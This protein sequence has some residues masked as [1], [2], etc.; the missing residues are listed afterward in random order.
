MQA[1]Q[2]RVT[3]HVNDRNLI[4]RQSFSLLP[5]HHSQ[6][7][8]PAAAFQPQPKF[9]SDRFH[10]SVTS[11]CCPERSFH[12]RLG[13]ELLQVHLQT[14]QGCVFSSVMCHVQPGAKP[15]SS[16]HQSFFFLAA[17]ALVLSIVRFF[18]FKMRS[19]RVSKMTS[20]LPSLF[21]PEGLRE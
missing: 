20:H 4:R 18:S 3:V 21:L 6:A 13:V 14:T 16:D 10:C 12:F 9:S 7:H 11:S 8:F 19:S 1:V 17:S 2:Q 5:L 15:T